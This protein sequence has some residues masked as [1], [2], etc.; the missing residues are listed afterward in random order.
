MVQRNAEST[1]FIFHRPKLLGWTLNRPYVKKS[2]ND[3][4]TILDFRL[5]T[6]PMMLTFMTYLNI[7]TRFS[8]EL[9]DMDFP[10]SS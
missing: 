5:I 4:I 10:F 6:Q 7:P 8:T 3:G 1:Q 9:T 2:Q